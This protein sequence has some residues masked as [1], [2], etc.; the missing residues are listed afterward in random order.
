MHVEQTTMDQIMTG[1]VGFDLPVHVGDCLFKVLWV[2]ALLITVPIKICQF[3]ASLSVH[4]FIFQ[5]FFIA[6]HGK[7]FHAQGFLTKT[8]IVMKYCRVFILL[9]GYRIVC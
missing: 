1:G 8:C 6:F 2:I 5:C 9:T 7:I 4:L 3:L